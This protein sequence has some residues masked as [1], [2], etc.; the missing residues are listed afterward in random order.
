MGADLKN[1]SLFQRVSVLIQP[2]CLVKLEHQMSKDRIRKSMFS[3]VAQVAVWR[4]IPWVRIAVATVFLCLPGLLIL[5]LVEMTGLK[6]M[7]FVIFAIGGC[8]DGFYVF[9]GKTTIRIVSPGKTEDITGIFSPGKVRRLV[10]RMVTNI[11]TTQTIGV[12][13]AAMQPVITEPVS[14][15]VRRS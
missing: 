14:G 13:A 10:A 15:E 9:C 8:V 6:I 11:R 12:P 2:D 3:R 4:Q 1:N 5:S 7:G